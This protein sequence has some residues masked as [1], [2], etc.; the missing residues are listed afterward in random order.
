MRIFLFL[1]LVSLSTISFSQEVAIETL[2]STALIIG[3][4]NPVNIVA[5]N[6]DCRMLEVEADNA[7]LNRLIDENLNC[8]Y[9]IIPKT[10]GSIELKIILKSKKGRKLLRSERL[11]VL[12]FPT[13][14]AYVKRNLQ[15]DFV[16]KLDLKIND[17]IT[18]PIT[19]MGIDGYFSVKSYKYKFIRTGKIISEGKITGGKFSQDFYS[20]LELLRD[21]DEILF[22]DIEVK[23]ESIITPIVLQ[24]FKIIILDNEVTDFISSVFYSYPIDNYYWK[25][26]NTNNQIQYWGNDKVKTQYIDFKPKEKQR[27]D[28]DN[29]GNLIRQCVINQKFQNDTLTIFDLETYEERLIISFGYC[30]ILNGPI[31]EY[32]PYKSEKIIRLQGQYKE[33]NKTGLWK[34]CKEIAPDKYECYEAEFKDDVMVG[35]IRKI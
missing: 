10:S 20:K 2:K 24:P 1:Y 11:R 21:F 6:I 22:Y 16:S 19:G 35:E 25:D 3:M 13:Q 29:S 28:Y 30:D 5:N 26:S 23:L 32:F 15:D 12:Q 27:L 7:I 31:T 14:K 33:N 4:D 8:R 9:N 17:G 34:A 18:V